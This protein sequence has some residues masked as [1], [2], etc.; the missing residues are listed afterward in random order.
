[1]TSCFHLLP[2]GDGV[3]GMTMA[4]NIGQSAEQGEDQDNRRMNAYMAGIDAHTDTQGEDEEEEVAPRRRKGRQ[5]RKVDY[6]V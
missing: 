6:T 1:M 3:E 5:A 4:R 2:V